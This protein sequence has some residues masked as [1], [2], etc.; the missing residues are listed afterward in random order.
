MTL[1]VSTTAAASPRDPSET[2]ASSS[3]GWAL[4]HPQ[5]IEGARHWTSRSPALATGR[6]ALAVTFA[7]RW[8]RSKALFRSG[9]H[10]IAQISPAILRGTDFSMDDEAR[11]PCAAK[12]RRRSACRT[13]S[14]RAK[15]LTDALLEAP[16]PATE[17]ILKDIGIPA[18]K[19][20]PPIAILRPGHP[21]ADEN[22]TADLR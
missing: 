15:D 7:R 12:A 16:T 14:M 22:F 3:A 10:S 2:G 8:N 5:S 4:A 11:S 6:G 19:D 18:I 17:R 9:E 1:A 20:V 21:M 13:K